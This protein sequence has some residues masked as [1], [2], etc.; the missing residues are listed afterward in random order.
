MSNGAAN[1]TKTPKV[2]GNQDAVGFKDALIKVALDKLKESKK[3]DDEIKPVPEDGDG[4][5]ETAVKSKPGHKTDANGE[6]NREKERERA[7]VRD[8]GRDSD[9]ERE[10][11]KEQERERDKLKE[12]SH[13]AKEKGKDSGKGNKPIHISWC[14]CYRRNKD[15][16]QTVCCPSQFCACRVKKAHHLARSYMCWAPQWIEDVPSISYKQIPGMQL[17]MW[18]LPIGKL[19]SSSLA[20]FR[21]NFSI[22]KPI[23]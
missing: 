23:Y 1:A 17:L 12:R 6:R 2:V 21:S 8:R 4:K 20:R 7:K 10:Q 22:R 15:L 14:K 5:E 18:Y 9:W 13:R 19:L 3:S 11:E 16:P